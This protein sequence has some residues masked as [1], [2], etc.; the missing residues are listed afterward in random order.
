MPAI[1]AGPPVRGKMIIDPTT[2]AVDRRSVSGMDAD[3]A[4]VEGNDAADVQAAPLEDWMDD[5]LE[6]V[7]PWNPTFPSHCIRSLG[8]VTS[9]ATCTQNLKCYSGVASLI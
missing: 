3:E 9:A 5:R 4:V 1:A 7:H 6:V 8:T 2:V